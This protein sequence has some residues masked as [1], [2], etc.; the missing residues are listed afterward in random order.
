MIID[1]LIVV[2]C[3]MVDIPRIPQL[4]RLPVNR[5]AELFWNAGKEADRETRLEQYRLLDIITREEYFF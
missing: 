2:V 4:E 3:L 1:T 5:F